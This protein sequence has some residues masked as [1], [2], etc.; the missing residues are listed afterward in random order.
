[1]ARGNVVLELRTVQGARLLCCPL[2]ALK[3][4]SGGMGDEDENDVN[5]DDQVLLTAHYMR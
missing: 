5:D 4:F 1:M 3:K 2:Y